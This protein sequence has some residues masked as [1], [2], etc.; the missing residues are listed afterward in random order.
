[1]RQ[2]EY[3]QFIFNLN[4]A[5]DF[6]LIEKSFFTKFS[7]LLIFVFCFF[8]ELTTIYKTISFNDKLDEEELERFFECCDLTATPY[9]IQEALEAVL[10]RKFIIYLF[11]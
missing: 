6:L 7:F 5:R 1:M 2:S 11:L 3:R 10:Q 8:I 4:Q 9:E